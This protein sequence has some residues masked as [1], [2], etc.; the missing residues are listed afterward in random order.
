MLPPPT[1]DLYY[2]YTC[3]H[4][5]NIF[6]YQPLRAL[7]ICFG[8]HSGQMQHTSTAEGSCCRKNEEG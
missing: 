5:D 4:G 7:L 2:F 3:N 8:F 6:V 1:A